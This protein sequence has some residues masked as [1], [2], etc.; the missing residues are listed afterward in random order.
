M[1]IKR[2]RAFDRMVIMTGRSEL[3]VAAETQDDGARTQRLN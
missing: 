1:K 2:T 3:F